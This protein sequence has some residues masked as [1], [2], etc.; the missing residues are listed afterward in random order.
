V[1]KTG[2]HTIDLQVPP[3]EAW[4]VLVAPGRRDWYYRLTPEG[5][6]T[7]GGHIRWVDARGELV[8]ESDVA[9]VE[10]PRRLV[11][12]TRFLFAPPFAAA[13]PHEVTWE[14]SSI[15]GGS[16]I[17]MSWVAE[18][19]VH[20]LLQSEGGAQLQGLRL[21]ADPSARAEVERL[22][23]IGEVQIRD[24]TPDLV[25]E[26]QHFF[27]DVAFRDFPAWQSCYCMETHRTQSDEE[28]AVRTGEDNRRDMS[29]SIEH[30]SVTALL[31]FAGGE[32]VGWCNYGETTHLAG[33]MSRFK[34]APAD[35]EGIG[36]VACFVIAAPYRGHGVASKLLDA[37]IERLRARGLRAVE[38]YPSR[39][40]D[41]SA[42]SNYRG[43]LDMYLRAGFEPYRELE[44]HVVVR[45]VLD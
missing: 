5:D 9:T 22:P 25:S 16:R 12:R 21:A 2:S 1:S 3:D 35:Q 28:W 29:D 6:F 20:Q 38:A 31:A 39:D 32:P 41:E 10:P 15:E 43:P 23:E 13:P 33:V 18:D 40:S 8:E 37:A 7:P 45:K 19:P 34:L 17:R 14:V 36:S 24:L 27:D 44:R 4:K 26:Y 42:Q 30:G 11:L